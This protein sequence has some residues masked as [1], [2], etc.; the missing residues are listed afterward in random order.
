MAHDITQIISDYETQ[1]YVG[2]VP[3]LSASEAADH[4]GQLEAAEAAFGEMHYRT[5]AHTIL[6]SAFQLATR[7]SV[8]DIVEGM[9]GPNILLYNTT[10]IIKEAQTPSFVSWHQDLTYWGLSCDDQVTMWLALSPASLESGCMRFIP[11]SHKHGMAHH[12]QTTDDD[13]VLLLGQTVSHVDED[14]A[15]ACPLAAGEASFHHGW[16]L[17]ASMANQSP[18][19]RIGLNIQYLA[20]HVRQTK[21]DLDTAMLVRGRDEYHHFEADKAASS[22]LHPDDIARQ[23]ALEE[24]YIAINHKTQ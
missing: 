9:I 7:D 16:T 4:R 11:G 5:K 3:L 15:K 14:K 6:T 13:N 21:H 20:T 10:Y 19:R 12:Q 8:L 22:D 1:G 17:H 2:P 23:K 24:R 18:D